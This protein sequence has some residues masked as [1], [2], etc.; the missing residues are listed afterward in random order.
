MM[1][2]KHWRVLSKKF[3]FRTGVAG[4]DLN[5]VI[6]KDLC[7]K[8]T[9]QFTLA[10]ITVGV[11]LLFSAAKC[12]SI[13]DVDVTDDAQ[14]DQTKDSGYADL[15]DA[16][17]EEAQVLI[18]R[19]REALAETYDPDNLNSAIKQLELAYSL[20]ETEKKKA[21]AAL[22][23]SKDFAN[24][25]YY[26]SYKARSLEKKDAVDALFEQADSLGADKLVVDDYNTA[27]QFYDEA[28]SAFSKE[29]Y[30][31]SY[32]KYTDC[33][34]FLSD[35]IK[36][37]RLARKEFEDRID[38]VKGLIT[39]ADELG[40]REYASEEFEMANKYLES[41]IVEY[42]DFKFDD[43]NRSLVDAEKYALLAIDKTRAALKELKRLEALKAIREA[44]KTIEDA[45][46]TD[47][48]DS[49]GDKVDVGNYEFEFDPDEEGSDMGQ[50]PDTSI[51]S[52]EELFN[53]A[54]EYIDKAKEAYQN[55]EYELAIKYADLAR[56]I[57]ESYKG[58]G[59]KTTYT[60]RLIPNR[61]DCLWRISEYDY[62]YRDPY[63]WPR[64]W[65][66]NK[67]Q[68]FNPDLIYPGQKFVIPEV[69]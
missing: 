50:A 36:K 55:E 63:L 7:M 33:E 43:A 60:V 39:E 58:S 34:D 31:S 54:V 40:A 57:A 69:D 1:R 12:K 64:I 13:G 30:V 16:D 29:D 32:M 61:R 37:A 51:S 62:I 67:K 27:R 14:T 11:M 68:I 20:R 56:R 59:I 2:W 38:Y 15:S 17:F 21:K 5:K 53:K 44:G 18:E 49:E 45:S 42:A 48:Y 52:Y 35:V 66:A 19:A 41:A 10:I 47:V 4:N 3:R 46:K 28:G 6:Y 26:N 65:K 25:A 24:K 22:E 23:A 8:H 9:L